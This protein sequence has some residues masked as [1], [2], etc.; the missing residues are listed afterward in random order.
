MTPRDLSKYLSLILRHDPARGHITLDAEGWVDLDLLVKNSA[1]KFTRAE[2]EQVVASNDKQRFAIVNNRIRANQGHT[3][4][5][6]LGLAAVGEP[7]EYLYHGT[8]P[9]AIPGILAEGLK[10]MARHHV[11]L[12]EDTKTAVTVGR[13][14]GAPVLY[15]V[16]ARQMFQDGH[17][18]Y[19]SANG[20][21]LVDA[22]PTQYLE[23]R[24]WL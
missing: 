13:R 2:V 14:S 10:K 11:H 21:W 12:A 23:E 19:R 20:V 3:I 24:S 16:S 15:R 4:Q 22:V 17:T 7:P 18:F 5:V 1:G 6:D 8:F 9:A